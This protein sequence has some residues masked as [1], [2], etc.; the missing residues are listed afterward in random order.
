MRPAVQSNLLIQTPQ[1]AVTVRD[2]INTQVYPSGTTRVAWEPTTAQAW[3]KNLQIVNFSTFC[4]TAADADALVTMVV[5][6]WTNPPHRNRI[7]VG[8]WVKRI[9][10]F[11]DEGGADVVLSTQTK[12]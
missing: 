11:E 4:S 2:F 8:S 10:S 7:E 12:T 1:D 3:H 9:N 6:A 5:D